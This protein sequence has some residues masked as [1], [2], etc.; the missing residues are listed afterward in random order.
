MNSSI[1]SFRPLIAAVV[2]ILLLEA[3]VYSLVRPNFA[4]RSNYLGYNYLMPEKFFK[5]LIFEKLRVFGNSSPD[6]VQVGDSTGLHNIIPEVVERYLGGLKYIDMS[7]CAPTGFDG[8]YTIAKAVLDR[9]PHAKALVLYMSLNDLPGIGHDFGDQVG[10]ATNL[11]DTFGA[12][13]SFAW[14]PTMAL[15]SKATAAVFSLGGLLRPNISELDQ[16]GNGLVARQW[17]DAHAGWWPELDARFTPGNPK[18]ILSNL[19]GTSDMYG[20]DLSPGV[21]NSR[22][23]THGIFGGSRFV[24]TAVFERFAELAAAHGA[25]LVLAFQPHP[26]AQLY[27]PSSKNPRSIAVTGR[28]DASRCFRDAGPGFRA[29]AGQ[30]VRH[31]GS[32]ARGL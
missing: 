6:V 12:P 25:K 31:A 16:N 11:Y 21:P 3:V 29:L 20:L 24:P 18:S 7:C 1:S 26:C 14:P 27:A 4:E 22:F 10:G 17:L 9:D 30:R 32:S 23:Y 19:C 15:R 5:I 2:T 28:A 8:Y 13:W